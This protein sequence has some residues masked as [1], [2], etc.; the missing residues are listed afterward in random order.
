MNVITQTCFFA[1][2]L[3]SLDVFAENDP[4]ALQQRA[5]GR[6]D[7]CIET[8]RKTGDTACFQPQSETELSVA[9]G[10]LLSSYEQLMSQGDQKAASLSLVR[11]GDVVRLQ[12]RWEDARKEFT[13]AV[14]VA[15]QAGSQ[16]SQARAELGLSKVEYFSVNDRIV[17]A[18]QREPMLNPVGNYQPA[19]AHAR[20][21]KRLAAQLPDKRWLFDA[22]ENEAVAEKDSGHADAA[23]TIL[24]QAKIIA[25]EVSDP[26][27]NYIVLADLGS[28]AMVRA[29]PCAKADFADSYDACLAFLGEAKTHYQQATGIARK[30]GFN[31]LEKATAD[32]VQV[33]KEQLCMLETK[34]CWSKASQ[35]NVTDDIDLKP[36]QAPED[37]AANKL[38]KI[39][40][41]CN[42]PCAEEPIG[43]AL[44]VR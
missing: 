11:M 32:L 7:H 4:Y 15:Q 40:Q 1:L 43:E 42:K 29:E 2:T 3:A 30:A 14:S 39:S 44:K 8:S 5:M 20:E 13:R 24:R 37:W 35:A 36:G 33:S 23:D 34:A 9:Y 31:Y 12:R 25:R 6:I 22:L 26:Y 16:E 38:N 19:I 18:K 17:A 28:V 10:E 27:R 21:A 41:K